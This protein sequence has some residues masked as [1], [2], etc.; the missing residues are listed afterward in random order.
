MKTWMDLFDN[1]L[2]D[3]SGVTFAAASRALREAAQEFCERTKVWRVAMDPVMTVAGSSIY[4]FDL[5]A[6][7][8]LVR[9]TRVK[10]GGHDIAGLLHDQ[11]GDRTQGLIALTPREFMLQP[12]PDPG[13][14][15]EITAVLKPSNTARG[16]ED[17]L[18]AHHAKAIA[19]GARAKLVEGE[20]AMIARAEFETAI[21]RTRI[22]VATAYGTAPLRTKP[23]FM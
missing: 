22:Q 4:D 5:T 15:V 1:Y 8:E 20:P 7:Q 23:S 6:D 16:I 11:E 21:G 19:C 3:V 13:L 10:L 9:F 12:A 14:K 2:S 18:Y 17:I